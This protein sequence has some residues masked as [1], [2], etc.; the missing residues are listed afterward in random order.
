MNNIEVVILDPNQEILDEL[1]RSCDALGA[2][3]VRKVDRVAYTHPPSGL[4]AIFLLVPAAEK[5]GSKPILQAQVLRTS[6]EDQRSGMPRYVVAGGVLPR[7]VPREPV[8][9]AKMV[10]S[11]A[12]DAVREFNL[13]SNGEGIHKLGFWAVNLLDGVTPQQLSKILADVL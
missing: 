9:D 4:D 11:N 8:K 3:T 12:L 1:A 2:V 7:D 6:P 13:S 5:W 10:I